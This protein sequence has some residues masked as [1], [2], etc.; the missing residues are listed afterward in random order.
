MEFYT[1]MRIFEAWLCFGNVSSTHV[2]I[3]QLWALAHIIRMEKFTARAAYSHKP[4]CS[5]G[6]MRMVPPTTEEVLLGLETKGA[7]VEIG[8]SA[9]SKVF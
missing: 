9:E 6:N 8:V 7:K 5:G 1:A 4:P 2:L 3:L